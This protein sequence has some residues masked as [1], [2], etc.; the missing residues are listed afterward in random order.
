MPGMPLHDMLRAAVQLGA[1][2]YCVLS[3]FTFLGSLSPR[4]GEWSHAYGALGGGLFGMAV[5]LVA[6]WYGRW[7]RAEDERR[8]AAAVMAQV[9]PP[10]VR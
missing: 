1:A 5:F 3:A 2:V 6:D 7:C 4:D 8:R 9:A 10:R